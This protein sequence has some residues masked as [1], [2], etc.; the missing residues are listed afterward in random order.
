MTPTATGNAAIKIA[1]EAQHV[2]LPNGNGNTASKPTLIDLYSGSQASVAITDEAL[3]EDIIKGL[4]GSQTYI[5]PGS[6]DNAED[7]KFAFRR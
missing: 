1:E 2:K 3:R 5:I 4:R 6:V 7:R